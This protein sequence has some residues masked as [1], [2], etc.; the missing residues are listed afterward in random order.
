MRQAILIARSLNL[1]KVTAQLAFIAAI[2]AAGPAHACSA[3]YF[4]PAFLD[5]TDPA[6][7]SGVALLLVALI[8]NFARKP[9][10]SALAIPAMFLFISYYGHWSYVG[11][12][13]YEIVFLNRVATILAAGWFVYESVKYYRYRT[14]SA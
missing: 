9:T 14:K 5:V 4:A 2:V 3:G 8:L 6:I 10:F 7:G 1:L 12:C 11:D 13:G